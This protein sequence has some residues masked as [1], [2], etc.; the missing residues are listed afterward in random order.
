MRIL[1]QPGPLGFPRVEMAGGPVQTVSFPLRPGLTLH[2]AV[3]SP[4]VAAGFQG[5][6]VVIEGGALDPFRYVMP[7]P[8]DGPSH[9]AYFTA[10]RAPAGV[11]RLQRANLTFGWAEGV[12]FLHC[13]AVWVEPDGSRRGGHILPRETVVVEAGAATAW[14]C[15]DVTVATGFDPET[16]FTLFGVAG[17]TVAGAEAVLAR[18]RPNVDITLAVEEIAA[19]RGWSDAVV[20]GS[21]GSLVGAAFAD[22]RIV[23]DLATEVLI[24]DGRVQGGRAELDLAVVDMEGRVYEGILARAANAVLITF[25]LMLSR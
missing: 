14:G 23:A 10:P 6:T 9:V 18:V 17:G 15:R 22:G 2:E 24:R 19:S 3:T 5:G 7:G 20:R 1:A 11:T 16:N 25:D 21:L 13:H 8:P 4:L 12:P